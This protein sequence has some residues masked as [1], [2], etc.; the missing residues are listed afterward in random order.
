M[1]NL[2]PIQ[3]LALF[4]YLLLRITISIILLLLGTQL[5][6]QAFT[7]STV[8]S[9]R[10][11]L[12]GS[13]GI[14]CLFASGLLLLGLFTQAGALF[15]AALSLLQLVYPN[16]SV[17]R[18]IPHPLFWFLLLGASIALFITGAGAFAFDLPI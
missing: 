3:F 12:I 4:G 10:P 7:M 13:L 14:G 6:Q 5:T 15:T 16:H 1:L 17:Q 2:V 18:I 8:L 11:Y 9:S